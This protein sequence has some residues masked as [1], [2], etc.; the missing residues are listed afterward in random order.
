MNF[1][2]GSLPCTQL[3][4][5]TGAVTTRRHPGFVGAYSPRC[6]GMVN[7]KVEPSPTW[8]VTQIRVL[9]Q[10]LSRRSSG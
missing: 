8:L 10:N 7:V 6:T 3:R 9:R 2:T 1:L 5:V 4:P